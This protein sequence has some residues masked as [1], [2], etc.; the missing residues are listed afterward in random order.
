MS[1]PLIEINQS[2]NGPLLIFTGSLLDKD[3]AEDGSPAVAH[4]CRLLKDNPEP[5]NVFTDLLPDVQSSLLDDYETAKDAAE[6]PRK[7]F[8]EKTTE[9]M[10]IAYEL[11]ALKDIAI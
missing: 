7:T 2:I 4:F 9:K 11:T 8:L 1:L 5:V 10:Y 3:A 6:G